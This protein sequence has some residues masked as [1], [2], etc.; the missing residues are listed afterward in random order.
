MIVYTRRKSCEIVFGQG[1][2]SP[3]LH[4]LKYLQC[5]AAFIVCRMLQV[6]CFISQLGVGILS[7]NAEW[8]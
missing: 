6:F 7:V 3:R 4:H 2:D 5:L 1:F 8:R